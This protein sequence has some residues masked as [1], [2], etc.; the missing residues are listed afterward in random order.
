MPTF[1]HPKLTRRH[2]LA[3]M[4]TTGVGLLGGLGPLR[5]LAQATTASGADQYFVFCYFSGGWDLLLGLDPRD[6]DVFRRE[7][8]GDTLIEPAYATIVDPT[9]TNDVVPSSV[10]GMEFGP[11]IGD[12]VNWADRMTL[13]RGMSMDTLTHEVGR[14]RFLTGKAPAGLQARGSSFGTVMAGQLGFENPIPQLSAKVEAYNVDQPTYATALQVDNVDDLVTVLAP[15]D[16]GLTNEADARIDALLEDWRSCETVAA[17]PTLISSLDQRDAAKDLVDQA[18]YELF[19]FGAN[20]PEM[21]AI[22]DQYGFASNDL[23]SAGAQAAMA[24][25]ALTA[26]ISRVAT[27]RVANGLDTH[28]NWARDHGSTLRPGF[29]VIAALAAD[30]DSRPFGND[31]STWLDH[32][33]IVA[34]S[35][36]SRTPLLNSRAGRDHALMNACMLLGGGLPGGTVIGASSDVGMNPQAVDLVTGQ[37]DPAGEILRPEHVLRTLMTRAGVLD[38]IA[39]LRVDP[40]QALL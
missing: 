33:T 7:L 36:F 29:D 20:T 13:V 30:L 34:F 27:I 8:I 25:T 28:D 4:A 18:L 23:G 32:T 9:I 10:P 15:G 19:D 1:R 11:Y 21:Q 39:D 35:E 38:D 3:G 40:I 5:Q 17:S 37:L 12:L 6:P 16:V 26:G 22:R 24:V 2:L 31:G 14:K